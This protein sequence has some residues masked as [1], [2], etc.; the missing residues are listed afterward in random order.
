MFLLVE[1]DEVD[2]ELFRRAMDAHQVAAEL[3]VA[4]DG[5]EAIELLRNLAV[6]TQKLIVFLDLNMPGV[7]GF[8]FLQLLRADAGLRRT[9]VF[10]LTSSS[11]QRD[12]QQAYDKNVA[13]YFVKS[14]LDALMNTVKSYADSVEYPPTTCV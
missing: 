3:L 13:G 2:V 1:D 6:G 9:L 7:N 8:E 14:N 11:H 5:A 12:K 4:N 10:I